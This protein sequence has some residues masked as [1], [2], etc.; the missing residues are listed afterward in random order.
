M[1]GPSSGG[2]THTQDEELL[3]DLFDSL[4]QEILDGRTPDLSSLHPDRPDLRDRITKTWALACSVA[5]RREPSRPVLGGYEIVRE[6]GHGGMGTVYLARHLTLQR[7][8]AIKVLPHSL[9]MSPRAKQRFVEEARALAQ[10]RHEHIVHIHRIVDHAEML[11]FEMEYIDG[12]SLQSLIQSLRQ[13]QKPHALQSL[14]AT[15]GIEPQALGTRSTVEWFVRTT[16]RIARA[17]AHVHRHGLVHR[18]IKPSNVLLRACGTPVLADFGLALT[19]DLDATSSRFAGTPVYAAPERLRGGEDRTDARTDIYSLGVTLFEAL[20][21]SPPFPGNTTH[22]VLRRIE[23]GRTPTLRQLAPHV[24]RD[25]ATVVQKAMESDPRHRYGS[26]DE[27]ADDL[28]RLLSLQPIQARPAGPLRRSWQFVRRNQ[29]LIGAAIAGALLVTGMLWPLAAH[30]AAASAATARA[31]AAWHAARSELLV[32]ECLPSSWTAEPVDGRTMRQSRELEARGAAC[33]RA[34]ASY[35]VAL[36]AT[37]ADPALCSERAVVAAALALL[38]GD[39]PAATAAPSLPPLCRQL[40]DDAREHRPLGTTAT[41]ALAQATDDDRYAAG[42]FAFLWGDHASNA[43]CWQSLPAHRQDALVDACTALRLA[44]SGQGEHAYPRL[45]HAARAFPRASALALALADAA[46]ASGDGPLAEHWIAQ[47][48]PADHDAARARRA[49][50]DADLLAVSGQVDEARRRYRQ[51]AAQESTDP[52]PLQRLV[53]LAL[54]DGNHDGAQRMLQNL[55]QRWPDLGRVRYQLAR[56]ALQRRATAEYLAHARHA[57]GLLR[58]QQPNAAGEVGRL[59][60]AGGLQELLQAVALAEPRSARSDD[61]IPLSGWLPR[62]PV[63]GVQHLLHL[64]AEFDDAALATSRSDRRPLGVMLQAAWHT[65]LLAPSATRVL[66][67][68]WRLCSL[69]GIPLLIG[70]PTTI[71]GELLLPFQRSLGDRLRVIEDHRLFHSDQHGDDTYYGFQVLRVGDPDGDTLEELCVTAPPNGTAVGNGFVQFRSRQDGSLLR[72]WRGDTEAGLYGRAVVALGDLDGDLCPDLA[73]SSPIGST[74]TTDRAQVELRSGRTGQRLWLVENPRES[75]GVA[76]VK[77]GDLDDD[78]HA[79]LLVGAPPLQLGDRGWAQILSGR[80]GAA[81]RDLTCERTGVWFGAEL[82][83]AGDLTGDGIDEVAIG[84]NY[85]GAPG[86]VAVLD[87]RS[88]QVLTTYSEAATDSWFG[89]AM[90]GCD[91]VDG[92]GRAELAIGAPG[93]SRASH[94][95]GRVVVLSSRTGKALYELQGE[96][97]HE[98]FGI[99]LCRLPDWRNDGRPVLAVAA[100]GGGPSGGGYI[101]VFDLGSGRPLQTFAGHAG[102]SRFGYGL[103]DLG[104]RA[105]DGLRTLGAMSHSGGGQVSFWELT[106]ADAFGAEMVPGLLRPGIRASKANQAIQPGKAIKP[107]KPN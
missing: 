106:Y 84:G 9:A 71:A 4:L 78:G 42:L 45:F 3:A 93:G 28:E 60:R 100:S 85:G 61:S 72:E 30:A 97:A 17:L 2:D 75:F 33:R 55:L 95:A 35:D 13:Q 94:S 74:G 68:S 25:L 56:V 98:R 81:L 64:L 66:P 76:M 15:L 16:I 103:V 27:F 79:D 18:D 105:G 88:G 19:G 31:A 36:A 51:L 80:T 38:D 59:L 1:N 34:L 104:Y 23:S 41:A 62:D 6:L 91:D 48:P 92:D 101:R 54:H 87:T 46:L 89:A 69:V 58:R 70:R 83:V 107:I 29:R 90:L 49:L 77:L 8:V 12:P 67:G 65:L 5:G 24:S 99:L 57:L 40:L 14:A 43:A 21:L 73:V 44:E 26:A 22:E 11:A 7:D 52:R 96:R 50:L 82:A 53:E 63:R 47:L 10:L 37:P 39:P 102:T 32:P 86:F 20:S